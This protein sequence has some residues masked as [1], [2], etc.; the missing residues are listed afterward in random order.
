MQTLRDKEE[1]RGKKSP[2]RNRKGTFEFFFWA[3]FLSADM[4]KYVTYFGQ[5]FGPRLSSVTASNSPMR[6]Q[7]E[8][9][10]LL[11]T[12]PIWESLLVHRC[13]GSGAGSEQSRVALSRGL[14]MVISTLAWVSWRTVL[15]GILCTSGAWM[16][17]APTPTAPI[18]ISY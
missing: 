1:L 4:I 11:Q 8:P 10:G 12:S 15:E 16:D 9:Q 14:G 13:P 5:K 2:E 3:S 7:S 18:W 6:V 17:T